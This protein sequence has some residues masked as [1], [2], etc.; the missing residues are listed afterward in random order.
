MKIKNLFYFLL[1]LPLVFA[2]C[3]GGDEDVDKK[4]EPVLTATSEELL[5]LSAQGGEETIT[6]TLENPVE[7]LSVVA[8]A[9]VDWISDF[10]YGEESVTFTV[11]ANDTTEAREGVVTVAYTTLSFDVT[12]KQEGKTLEPE[13]SV[14]AG[15]TAEFEAAGGN[16][17]VEY[18]VK[19][20]VEGVELTATTEA[21]WV[22]DVKVDADASKVTYV[23][24]AN[25][26]SEAR[27]AK[28]VLSYGELKQEVTISQK[29]FVK[30]GEPSINL[31]SAAVAE[32]KAE[33]GDGV[34]EYELVDAQEDLTVKVEASAAWITDVKVDAEGSKATYKVAAND[35]DE[36]REAKLSLTYGA[37]KVEVTVKQEA[38]DIPDPELTLKSEA[39]KEFAA[40]G[41]DGEFAFELKN[42]V[43]GTELKAAVAADVK[44]I[45]DVKVDAEGSK[46]TYKVAA[47]DTEEAREAKVT[48]TYGEL[49][50]EVTVK[51]AAKEADAAPELTLKSDKSE[52]F[53]AEGGNGEFEYELK[54]AVE[55][56][57]LKA[58]VAVGVTWVTDVKVDAEKSKV[59][60]KVAANDKPEAREAKITVT[61]GELSRE[62][63]VKQEAFIDTTTPA[64][65]LKSSEEATRNATAGQ[66]VL[67][68]E[69][70]N[71]VEG[72]QIVATSTVDWIT[73]GEI[74]EEGKIPYTY[75]ENLAREERSGQIVVTYAESSFTF[76]LTQRGA[77]MS[78]N[79]FAN[80]DEFITYEAVTRSISY[81][82][83]FPDGVNSVTA[84]VE[85]L[86]PEG[87]EGWISNIQCNVDEPTTPEEGAG[88]EPETAAEEPE[89][90]LRG[91]VTFNVAEHS[92]TKGDRS[93]KITLT[94]GDKVWSQVLTQE[95]NFPDDV[96][97]NVVGVSASMR[98]GG[99]V[100]D[101]ILTEKDAALGEPMTQIT[102]A[103]KSANIQ[104]VASGTYTTPR[105]KGI[106]PGTVNSS[107]G[108]WTNSVYRYNTSRKEA[109]TSCELTIA[110]DEAKQTAAI[111]GLFVSKQTND[112]T[113]RTVDVNVIFE[114]NGPVQ[115]FRW[116]DPTAEITS[117]KTFAIDASFDDCK[118][119]RGESA[120]GNTVELFLHT[121]GATTGDA[122]AAGTYPVD[123]WTT[124]TVAGYCESNS[125]KVNGS[126]ITS[127]SVTVEGSGDNYT[128]RYE[129][130]D[131][132]YTYK[133]VYTGA[134]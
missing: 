89:D 93:A 130:S 128:V 42:A 24:A 10:V 8:S 68:Y 20:P 11:A 29:P 34:V 37:V 51:Q 56:T 49:K 12:V 103:M 57:E 38:L 1:A 13:L 17:V 54:N 132:T 14:V 115:G 125:T 58:A 124:E 35:K 21:D 32:F 74:V 67:R 26:K 83:K 25:E 30:E 62:Y 82:V 44:W 114:W 19:N 6:Y 111:S 85:Y 36:A 23:V 55:G 133:G 16:G 39:T 90:V 121:L 99:K 80:T 84:E 116:E 15:A 79:V 33:G 31:K 122:L 108:E 88:D 76:T 46:V 113:G 112:E 91:N 28:L 107:T 102:V 101:L 73:V 50:V 65:V 78:F 110:I 104:Y 92:T 7:G 71:P 118:V 95:D 127:G 96:V 72:E 77:T 18:E 41:G 52:V 94:Y 2:A 69:L 63:T 3:N 129:L 64:I 120:G 9:N 87:V 75:A 98:T 123:S 43:E 105:P 86:S 22:G 48:L 4:K 59:T 106:Y 117:W 40:E 61:Y 100:W 5:S 126:P 131:G 134:L 81:E 60:Y 70:V 27:S 119:I 47:N 53:T 97:M 66:G 45:T 109:I